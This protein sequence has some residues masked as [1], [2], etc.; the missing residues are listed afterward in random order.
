M[1]RPLAASPI[2]FTEWLNPQTSLAMPQLSSTAVP[3]LTEI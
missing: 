2:C 3:L 1:K